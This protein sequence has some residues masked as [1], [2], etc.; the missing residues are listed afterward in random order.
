MR[1]TGEGTA[2]LGK[3]QKRILLWVGVRSG[4]HPPANDNELGAFLDLWLES[5]SAEGKAGI[6]ASEEVTLISLGEIA[7]ELERVKTSWR[8]HEAE[9]AATLKEA[10]LEDPD[11]F[12]ERMAKRYASPLGKPVRWG[13]EEFLKRPPRRSESASISKAIR[14]LE[15]RGLVRRYAAGSKARKIR[16][17][18]HLILTPKGAEFC[19]AFWN[20][21]VFRILKAKN[22][23]L[24]LE[25][26]A[27]ILRIAVV[28][29]H[30]DLLR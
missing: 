12:L 19:F 20:E 9:L 15:K 2:R 5:R 17:V 7:A 8:G 4:I 21:K 23:A 22:D 1:L 10:G 27:I 6:E 3:L 16:R 25:K 24:D 18:S 14:G 11:V 29:A 28:E 30:N 26:D 13:N